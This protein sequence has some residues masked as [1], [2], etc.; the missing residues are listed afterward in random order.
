MMAAFGVG[1]RVAEHRGSLLVVALAAWAIATAACSGG[2]SPTPAPEVEA[3]PPA[4]NEAANETTPERA[5][6]PSKVPAAGGIAILASGVVTVPAATSFETAGF[7]ETY[8]IETMVPSE[9]GPAL[10]LRLVI[11]LHDVSRP[12][13]RCDREHPLSGCSTVDWSDL[14]GRPH[15]P[16][17]GVFDNRVTLSLVSGEHDFFLSES[18]ALKPTADAFSPG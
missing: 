15:V 3:T 13:Q 17:G 1:D 4:A 8:E 14:E 16:A 18:G 2:Q 7:H 10:G 12:N 9:L 5:V 11:S 6:R